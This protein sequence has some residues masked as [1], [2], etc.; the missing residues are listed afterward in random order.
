MMN[1]ICGL[2]DRFSMLN[3]RLTLIEETI[4]INNFMA[5]DTDKNAVGVGSTVPPDVARYQELKAKS[6]NVGVGSTAPS[7]NVGSGNVGS[8]NVGVGSTATSGTT[9]TEPDTAVDGGQSTPTGNVGVGSS[10]PD[11]DFS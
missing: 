5:E 9:E 10:A 7:G 4:G 3:E 11:P 1:K 2:D 8:G 6:G